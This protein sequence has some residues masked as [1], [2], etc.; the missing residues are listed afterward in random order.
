MECTYGGGETELLATYRVCIKKRCYLRTQGG[1][2]EASECSSKWSVT[3]SASRRASGFFGLEPG[4]PG[5]R[6]RA[7]SGKG[8]WAQALQDE[9]KQKIEKVHVMLSNKEPLQEVFHFVLGCFMSLSK[10]RR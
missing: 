4:D 6:Y 1:C 9:L 10:T 7:Q 5:T 8:A 2:K 3:G